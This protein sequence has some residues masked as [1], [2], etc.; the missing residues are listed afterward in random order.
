MDHNF[1]KVRYQHSKQVWWVN[2]QTF[3]AN[4]LGYAATKYCN[5]IIFSQVFTKVKGVTFFLKHSVETVQTSCYKMLFPDLMYMWNNSAFLCMNQFTD[6]SVGAYFFWPTPYI[7]IGNF[8]CT[9]NILLL[10][11]I[12]ISNGR[13]YITEKIGLFN[14]ISR[15][16]SYCFGVTID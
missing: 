15:Q 13:N 9:V 5:L 8:I 4:F 1:Y 7:R 16:I 11:F 10:R 2:M 6:R 3:V 14:S 12:T